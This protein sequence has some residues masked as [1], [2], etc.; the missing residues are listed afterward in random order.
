M[1]RLFFV[2]KRMDP[3]VS[4]S[5]TQLSSNNWTRGSDPS[6]D[7]DEPPGR[8]VDAVEQVAGVESV[9]PAWKAALTAPSEASIGGQAGSE[10]SAVDRG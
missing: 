5:T 7:R 1:L 3:G 10:V 2:S 6:Q 9:W 4:S 8:L